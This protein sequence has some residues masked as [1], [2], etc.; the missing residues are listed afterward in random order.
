MGDIEAYFKK[1]WLKIST[2]HQMFGADYAYISTMSP[3]PHW[4][5]VFQ[6]ELRSFLQGKKIIGEDNIDL[7]SLHE[8]IDPKYLQFGTVSKVKHQE[9]RAV[10]ENI[11]FDFSEVQTS[12]YHEFVK[13]LYV[14]IIKKDFYFQKIPTI[15]VRIPDVEGIKLPA[16]HCDSIL[17]H[18]PREIN[19]WFGITD[20]VSS[21][22]WV[23]TFKDSQKWFK[24]LKLDRAAWK[25]LCYAGDKEFAARG[26]INASEVENMYESIFMFDGRCV[27]TGT[28]R[29]P[30]D[31]TTKITMDMRIIL[32][33]E[34]EWPVIDGVPIFK[35]DG[36]R[37]AEFRPGAPYGYDAKSVKELM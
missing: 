28:H 18:S 35:G 11:M 12:L 19:V 20:N 30:D 36:I 9:S 5:Q 3:A 17:G 29:H 31:W 13:W 27:H 22:F 33:D 32:V 16:W 24:D 23:K 8:I 21:G 2:F 7:K 1:E 25:N 14:D 26:F 15:R 37:Q 6:K 4:N 34:Y 10:I